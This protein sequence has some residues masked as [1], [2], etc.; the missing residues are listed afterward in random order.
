VA[1][2]QADP[3]PLVENKIPVADLTRLYEQ[4]PQDDSLS[5]ADQ[6]T[7]KT[8]RRFLNG[9][10]KNGIDPIKLYPDPAPYN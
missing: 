4:L 7:L 8:V 9:E 1:L 2:Y 10:F 5:D 6:Q 3:T